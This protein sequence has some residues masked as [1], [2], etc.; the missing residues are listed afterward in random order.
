[1]AV[2]AY[3]T[4]GDQGGGLFVLGASTTPEDTCI[5]IVDST[6]RHWVRQLA[7][8]TVSVLQCGAKPDNA[9][10][11]AVVFQNGI[12]AL[13]DNF[14]GGTFYIPAAYMPGSSGAPS[15][16]V[17]KSEVMLPPFSFPSYA[18]TAGTSP[19]ATITFSGTAIITVGSSISVSGVTPPGYN[20]AGA[21]VTASAAGTVSYANAT[22]GVET[23][24]PGTVTSGSNNYTTTG[25][26]GT[27]TATITI[28]VN[29]LFPVGSLITV[30]GVVP[31]G[32]DVTNA[33][34]TASTA[35]SSSTV[36]Y[37]TTTTGVFTALGHVT[38]YGYGT[39]NAVS[40]S[41]NSAVSFSGNYLFSPPLA[42]A[43]TSAVAVS[44]VTPTG[45]NVSDYPVTAPT[46]AGASGSSVSY[47]KTVSGGSQ[48]IPG[49]VTV[50]PGPG[51]SWDENNP[52][53]VIGDGPVQTC[54]KFSPPAPSAGF[55]N[56]GLF[57]LAHS[58][59]GQTT[60]RD[61]NAGIEIA[62]IL[63][64][65]PQNFND[66]SCAIGVDNTT[67]PYIHDNWFQ[68]WVGDPN[69]NGLSGNPVNG[70]NV[71]GCG[72]E[73]YAY[74]KGGSFGANIDRNRFG[75]EQY[76]T[77]NTFT[78]YSLATMQ[79]VGMRYGIWLNGPYT[80]DGKVNDVNMTANRFE[81]YLIGGVRIEGPD[82][83]TWSTT[84]PG[85]SQDVT[86]EKN[87][88]FSY[89]SHSMETNTLASAANPTDITLSAANGIYNGSAL[90]GLVG[91]IQM[92]SGVWEGAYI[93]A[94][95]AASSREVLLFSAG[96]ALG[97]P[98]SSSTVTL[99]A[100]SAMSA[101][102][103]SSYV[104][105]GFY[106]GA[107]VVMTSGTC[108]GY[109]GTVTNYVGSSMLATVSFTGCSGSPASGDNYTIT[110]AWM[111]GP[112]VASGTLASSTSASVTLPAGSST[113]NNYYVNDTLTATSG[114]CIGDTGT[115]TGYTYTAGSTT[116]GVA[117][118]SLYGCVGSGSGPGASAFTIT[119]AQPAG[120]A[121]A[122]NGA[123]AG[124][125]SAPTA[126][127][128]TLQSGTATSINY[129]TN[130]L[131]TMVS[132]ACA[133]D[134][135]TI[136]SYSSYNVT[137][138]VSFTN[139]SGIGCTPS[140]TDKYS[141]T[142]P[143]NVSYSGNLAGSSGSTVTLPGPTL[144]YAA[145]SV[146]GYY[147]N[148][149]ITIAASSVTCPGKSGQITGYVGSSM[150]ATVSWTGCMTPGSSDAYTITPSAP[151][152][153]SGVLGATSSTNVVL[154][155]GASWAN[156][157]YT[158][159]VMTMTSGTCV[160]SGVGDTGTITNYAGVTL[161]ATVSFT[162]TGGSCTPSAGDTYT[163]APAWWVAPISVPTSIATNGS[164]NSITLQAGS[165]TVNGFYN[166]AFLAIT[167]MGGACH[168]K[169]ANITSYIG[170][171]TLTA[172]APLGCTPANGDT[173]TI[174]SNYELGYADFSA[175]AEWPHPMAIG[176]ATYLAQEYKY[177]SRG[178]YFE[179]TLELV[180]SG[181]STGC[182]LSASPG[183]CNPPNAA[184]LA[185]F[186]ATQN[187]VTRGRSTMYEDESFFM[188]ANLQ[189]VEPNASGQVGSHAVLGSLTLADPQLLSDSAPLMTLCL[190]ATGHALN[191][192][193]VV[194]LQA[195]GGGAN[196]NN[197]IDPANYASG[198]SGN[199]TPAEFPCFIVTAP[200]SALVASFPNGQPTTIAM[201]GSQVTAMVAYTS[202]T[203]VNSGALLL[204]QAPNATLGVNGYLIAVDPGSLSGAT[205]TSAAQ[206]VAQACAYAIGTASA[207]GS[208]PKFALLKVFTTR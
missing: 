99:A 142:P 103:F 192:G 195:N 23:G 77:S 154:A 52:F 114:A 46:M 93:T 12:A 189:S 66:S 68:G 61:Q 186:V 184:P 200:G 159:A 202:T 55:N 50:V 196:Y 48:T 108:K 182:T 87:K 188:P 158:G 83:T 185:D 88:Y 62:N 35:G 71:G 126:T 137:A 107:T 41:G 132:G 171:T 135:A 53:R 102:P 14:G 85:S 151:A 118:V 153:Y 49:L 197:C 152:S 24:T 175:R 72:I 144:P 3:A 60:N 176:H 164:V 105:D 13:N 96:G 181:S 191:V 155:A 11:N 39:T 80:T 98:S 33:V 70:N 161:L 193:D 204:P 145:S 205:A 65:G 86:S 138:T 100:G 29:Y 166:N 106:N 76:T 169:S 74:N 127:T 20:V 148:A 117:N 95:K 90:A 32:Y 5:V 139:A 91:R 9:T 194:S 78:L 136:T 206:E 15:C 180:A 170:G 157:F 28:G 16:Y 147:N 123:A 201:P 7:S 51:N 63:F 22:T 167:S 121:F 203:P 31:V 129:Y 58:T 134:T 75:Y 44:D 177:H 104:A 92:S 140:A 34:V 2:Q 110:P 21:I 198:T 69:A 43:T 207:L 1:M 6:S 73:V 122:A 120:T 115:I 125:A 84:W 168:G 174:N 113:V 150:V 8:S 27:G 54:W 178:D 94:A 30:S 130:S 40:V 160:V 172:T 36:S 4:P 208:T 156:S 47:G 143:L 116:G 97:T 124:G 149:I 141:I 59:L 119:P 10:D 45:Y 111:L 133:G 112:L 42:S 131:M 38:P 183:F 173:Y 82:R 109:S 165:S 57:A 101:S 187:E 199:G 64:I 163:I 19:T 162:G 89:I 81:G 190:N 128:V 17:T 146:N 79:N 67:A 56:S 179:N 26:S 37:A 18:I 25:A